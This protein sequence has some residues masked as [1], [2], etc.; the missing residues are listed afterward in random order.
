M[1]KISRPRNKFREGLA[2]WV[3]GAVVHCD[4]SSAPL[5]YYYY[6]RGFLRK[7]LMMMMMSRRNKVET[8]AAG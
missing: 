3:G 6:C 5:V 4:L 8:A 1:F 7:M 2:R